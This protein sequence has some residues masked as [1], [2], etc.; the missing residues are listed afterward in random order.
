ME[1][2]KILC[3]KTTRESAILVIV[4]LILNH[5]ICYAFHLEMCFYLPEE[6]FLFSLSNGWVTFDGAFNLKCFGCT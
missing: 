1:K 6:A 3:G 4:L 2:M 5:K